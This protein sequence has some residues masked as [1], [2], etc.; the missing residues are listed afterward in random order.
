MRARFPTR[1]YS[2]GQ[3]PVTF[4]PNVYKTVSLSDGS[5]LLLRSDN[6]GAKGMR[7]IPLTAAGEHKEVLLE[8]QMRH[9]S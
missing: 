8:S 5:L 9:L 2:Q 3:L 1:N 4:S 7:G 6:A